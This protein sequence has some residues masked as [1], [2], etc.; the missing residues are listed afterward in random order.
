MMLKF[1]VIL[2]E[3]QKLFLIRTQCHHIRTDKTI[4][5][6]LKRILLSKNLI[7]FFFKPMPV[8]AKKKKKKKKNTEFLKTILQFYIVTI[9]PLLSLRY[10]CVFFMSPS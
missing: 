2:H 3:T 5:S 6:H 10:T 1:V 9:K 4:Q 7:D 8:V